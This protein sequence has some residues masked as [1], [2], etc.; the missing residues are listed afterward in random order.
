MYAEIIHGGSPSGA[1]G[2]SSPDLVVGLAV[3][4]A[5]LPDPDLVLGRAA[6][7]DLAV[8]AEGFLAPAA[9]VFFGGELSVVAERLGWWLPVVAF[10]V[11]LPLLDRGLDTASEK[12][13]SGD[14]EPPV[15]CPLL[16]LR[17]LESIGKVPGLCLAMGMRD[18]LLRVSLDIQYSSGDSAIS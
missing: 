16:P 2:E 8:A 12:S 13:S 3:F 15:F 14:T 6:A 1:L 11:V 9:G 7:V 17:S 4:P 10:R 5:S 18:P